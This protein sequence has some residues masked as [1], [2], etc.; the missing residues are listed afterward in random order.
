MK[1]L[2]LIILLFGVPS[3]VRA[4][5]VC[6]YYHTIHRSKVLPRLESGIPF[7][8]LC[9]VTSGTGEMREKNIKLSYDLWDEEIELRT[10]EGLLTKSTLGNSEPLI[11]GALSMEDFKVKKP[12]T[13]TILFDVPTDAMSKILREQ[14]K[15]NAKGIFKVDWSPI[16]KKTIEKSL[17]LH[18]VIE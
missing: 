14:L 17:I 15:K 18:K 16:Q 13:L 6:D 7:H 5:Q 11:C 4:A 9:V 3:Q 8:L 12:Y 1:N 10:S 2:I